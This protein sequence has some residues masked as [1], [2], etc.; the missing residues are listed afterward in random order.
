MSR[1]LPRAHCV[2]PEESLKTDLGARRNI[3]NINKK[4]VSQIISSRATRRD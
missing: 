3:R 1:S 2:S 4:L